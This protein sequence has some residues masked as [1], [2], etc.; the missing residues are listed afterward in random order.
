MEE[1]GLWDWNP[2][3]Q[4]C[5]LDGTQWKVKIVYSDLEVESSGE[6]DYPDNFLEFWEALEDLLGLDL[7]LDI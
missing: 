3:Y 6:N 5:C 1:L 4:L 7:K 2:S